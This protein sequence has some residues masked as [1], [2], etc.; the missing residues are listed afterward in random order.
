MTELE[1]AV[2]KQLSL[3]S[4]EQLRSLDQKKTQAMLDKM[5][6][7]L[8][9][10]MPP[11]EILS[12]MQEV[13]NSTVNEY[14]ANSH[15]KGIVDELIEFM[16]LLPRGATVLELG[17]GPGRDALFMSCPDKDFR[18]SLM[19][20]LRARDNKTV[21]EKYPVPEIVLR[22]TGIDQ[23]KSMIA[24][25]LEALMS[26]KTVG[27]QTPYEPQFLNV[28]M[29]NLYSLPP[30][31]IEERFDAIWS[32]AALLVHTPHS[33]IH[34]TFHQISEL[35]LP[36]GI[37]SLSYTREQ[38]AGQYDKLLLSS[39]GAIKYFS[40][41]DPEKITEIAEQYD[42]KLEQQT[43]N[44]MEVNGQVKIKELF[45]SQLFRKRL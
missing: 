34:P 35:L 13:Y 45:V 23:S 37:F 41:P 33:L 22:V 32:C 4:L 25:S 36:N 17:C 10:K 40:Q 16:D 24:A 12:H 8:L 27:I 14:V 1:K 28:D 39:T 19:N 18:L 44:D 30:K 31:L 38:I 7:N 5:A 6:Q 21:A 26:L 3:E 2:L 15:N 9:P 29:H 42:L 43:F 11:S 20:R